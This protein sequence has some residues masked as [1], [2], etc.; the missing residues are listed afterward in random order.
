MDHAHASPPEGGPPRVGVVVPAYDGGDDLL[1]CLASVAASTT[2]PAT[3]VVVDN[4]STDGAVAAAQRRYT[5]IEVIR[6]ATNR[7]FGAACN[8]GV[9]VLL[10][11][12]HDFVLLLNQDALLEPATLAEMTAF[13]VAH[14]RAGVVGALTVSTR[15][16][17]DGAPVLLYNGAW[18]G[19]LPLWQHIPGIGR[20]SRDASPQPRRV[21]YVW[22]H[23]MLLRAAALRAVGG[24]DPGFFMYCEDLDLC[25]RMA[26]AGWEV[27]CDSAAVMRHAV[28]DG[29]RATQSE[30]WRW[31]MKMA[32]ARHFYRKEHRR[33]PA[34]LLW[35]LTALREAA[36]L[37]RNRHLRAAAHLLRAWWQV[38]AGR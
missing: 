28:A 2:P 29:A 31:R 5:A 1:A 32:S 11:T 8:Q 38:A 33:G 35:L 36:S 27:W 14:P 10:A 19:L 9:D 20:S 37:L 23:G 22:G 34:D 12:G 30:A 16:A 6:N 3:V 18:R 24:F 21:D 26:A 15:L 25:R 7:G 13:A 4:A 17:A